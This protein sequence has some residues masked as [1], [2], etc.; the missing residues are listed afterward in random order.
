MTTYL[1]DNYPEAIWTKRKHHATLQEFAGFDPKLL[2][3]ENFS[4]EDEVTCTTVRN[5]WDII[6]SWWLLMYPPNEVKNRELEWFIWN[7]NHSYFAKGNR[8]F[9]LHYADV[10]LKYETLAQDLGKLLNRRVVLPLVGKTEIKK[11]YKSYY[12]KNSWEAVYERF[13]EEIDLFGYNNETFETK[14]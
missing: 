3:C 10:Y 14:T 12:D 1:V 7:G 8:I 5:H 4:L 13:H 11:D 9:W 6:V 2:G